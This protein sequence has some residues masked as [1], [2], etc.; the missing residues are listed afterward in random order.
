MS[1]TV[2]Y[3]RPSLNRKV[4]TPAGHYFECEI[5]GYA[6]LL[7]C[8]SCKFP[9]AVGDYAK[10]VKCL[11]LCEKDGVQVHGS[12]VGTIRKVGYAWD[13]GHNSF[14]R[15]LIVAT[16]ECPRSNMVD[17]IILAVEVSEPTMEEIDE[18]Y[19]RQKA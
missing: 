5:H 19:P 16:V 10:V 18:A 1:A 3:L 8:P 6:G 11:Y 14:D 12:H 17:R 7:S 9:G 2:S 13:L 15:S 4:T